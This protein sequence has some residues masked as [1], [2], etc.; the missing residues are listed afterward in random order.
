[1]QTEIRWQE[2]EFDVASFCEKAGREFPVDAIYLFGSRRYRTDSVRSDIDMFFETSEHI[3]P[4]RLRV[5]ADDNCKALDIFVLTSETARSVVNESYICGENGR[6][7]LNQCSA[8]KLWSR[9]RGLEKNNAIPWK[10]LYASHVDFQ[11]TILPNARVQMSIDGLKRKLQ[12]EGLPNDP[13]IGETETEVAQRLVRLA[14]RVTEFTI[15]DFP[16]KGGARGSFVV[17][18]SSEYDFQDLF[19]IASKTWIRSIER[20]QVEIVFDGQK[21]ISDFNINGS[22]FI[23]EMKFAKDVDDKRNIAKTLDGLT[24]FYSENANVRVLVLIVYARRAADIDRRIWEDRYSK[25]PGPPIVV[26]NVI[27]VD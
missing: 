18:P 10:Q 24:R 9:G 26:L 20:E 5:F 6:E 11:K 2:L 23:I 27:E 3:K 1:M 7:I 19:W 17:N 25:S 14:E 8:I 21:K 4:S 12:N 16:G 15:A 13:I 22:R